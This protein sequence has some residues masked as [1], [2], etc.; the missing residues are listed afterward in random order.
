[1]NPRYI[2]ILRASWNDSDIV[3]VEYIKSLFGGDEFAI[4]FQ[5][6]SQADTVAWK[7][8]RNSPSTSK[9]KGKKRRR[10]KDAAT[11]GDVSLTPHNKYPIPKKEALKKS[12]N[13]KNGVTFIRSF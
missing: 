9:I 11:Y 10:R 13:P 7:N 2:Y 5:V 4:T 12:S 1:L 8:K 3:T 6:W